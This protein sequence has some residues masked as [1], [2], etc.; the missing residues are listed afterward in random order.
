[1]CQAVPSHE[2]APH[3]SPAGCWLCVAASERRSDSLAGGKILVILRF[4]KLGLEII[5]FMKTLVEC[6]ALWLSSDNIL[7]RQIIGSPVLT[8]EPSADVIILICYCSC[9]HS[10]F[11]SWHLQTGT[12]HKVRIRQI[13]IGCHVFAGIRTWDK[14]KFWPRDGGKRKA[15]E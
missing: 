3:A 9:L 10:F 12:K 11:D 5:K 2:A 4:P 6:D 15:M 1:M 8:L 13:Q 7:T 14:L